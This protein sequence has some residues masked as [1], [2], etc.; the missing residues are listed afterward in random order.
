[1][2]VGDFNFP[3]ITWSPF[4]WPARCDQFMEAILDIGF[5]QHVLMPTRVTVDTQNI[6]DLVFSNEEFMVDNVE[7]KEGF[8]TSDHSS[9]RFDCFCYAPAAA[10]SSRRRNWQRADW[11]SIRT[12][13]SGA[14]SHVDELNDGNEMWW[15]IK[16]AFSDCV[17]LFVPLP[18]R[19][20]KRCKPIWSDNQ[21]HRALIVQQ[22]AHR[23]FMRRKTCVRAFDRYVAA[24]RYA[25]AEAERSLA[26]FESKVAANAKHDSKSFWSYVN[27]KRKVKQRPTRLKRPDGSM[28]NCDVDTAEQFNEFFISVFTS[29]CFANFPCITARCENSIDDVVFCSEDVSR[30]IGQLK[31]HAAPGPDQISNKFMMQCVDSLASPLASLFATSF[32]TGVVPDDWKVASVTPIHKGGSFREANNFR[33]V[34][35][36]SAVCKLMER[37]IRDSMT[38]HIARYNLLNVSQ[39]GFRKARSCELQLIKYMDFVSW[40]VDSGDSADSVYLDFSKAFD[41]VP[42]RRLQLKLDAYGIRGNH[43]RWLSNF[44][45][46]RSQHVGINGTKSRETTLAIGTPVL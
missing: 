7:V 35:L 30:H 45:I 25:S 6:L 13:I 22:N 17:N 20:S 19:S 11:R 10:S 41:T 4:T 1:L 37:F 18:P 46:G 39:Y 26:R 3:E 36:T 5:T 32:N 31:R 29:E 21:A 23:S 14:L 15:S 44:L 38:S 34:S 42:H 9:V 43:L 33:P 2:L 12:F 24:S 40:I 28:T 27:S 16:A 8:G